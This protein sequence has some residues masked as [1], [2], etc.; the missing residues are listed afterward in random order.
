MKRGP[1]KKKIREKRAPKKRTAKCENKKI[2]PPLK[3]N[4]IKLK[5]AVTILEND[6]KNLEKTLHLRSTQMKGGKGRVKNPVKKKR[7]SH[8]K[9]NTNT[10]H[11]F[12]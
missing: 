2:K 5:I 3:K 6:N 4:K 1:N 8:N 7:V 12:Q 9:K 11:F 10:T